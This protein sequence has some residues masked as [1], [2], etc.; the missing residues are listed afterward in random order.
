M[1]WLSSDWVIGFKSPRGGSKT[2]LLG[3]S[4]LAVHVPVLF[5]RS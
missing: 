4:K 3:W 2:V 5:K 1:N